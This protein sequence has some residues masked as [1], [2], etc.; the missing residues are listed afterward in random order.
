LNYQDFLDEKKPGHS[1][2]DEAALREL[3]PGGA[4]VAAYRW[5][6]NTMS[7]TFVNWSVV[8]AIDEEISITKWREYR[9]NVKTLLEM[10]DGTAVVEPAV[11][12]R[13]FEANFMNEWNR[14]FVNRDKR[15]GSYAEVRRRLIGEAEA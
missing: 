3:L 4:A 2:S 14:E 7:G 15:L 9:K 1:L 5:Q 10:S 6:R 8:V 13:K 11:V 12:R